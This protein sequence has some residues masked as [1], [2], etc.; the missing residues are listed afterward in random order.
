MYA[1]VMVVVCG[2]MA[3]QRDLV[4]EAKVAAARADGARCIDKC[5]AWW[6]TPPHLRGLLPEYKSG[7]NIGG[8]RK[9]DLRAETRRNLPLFWKRMNLLLRGT[10]V[11]GG[12]EEMTVISIKPSKSDDDL[13]IFADVEAQSTATG[14]IYDEDTDLMEV[15][16]GTYASSLDAMLQREHDLM[17]AAR[18]A[19]EPLQTFVMGLHGR[20]GQDSALRRAFHNDLF[21]TDVMNLTTELA[22]IK[23]TADWRDPE[24]WKDPDPQPEPLRLYYPYPHRARKPQG[25]GKRRSASFSDDRNTAAARKRRADAAMRNN[26]SSTAEEVIDKEEDDEEED[27]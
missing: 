16:R 11:N 12:F 13:V 15:A 27:Q 1:C 21:A 8:V 6:L 3:Q 17:S 5:V 14:R 20:A 4:Y 19:D 25:P 24:E 9:K 10:V 23:P 7:G 2:E 18:E 26:H 22:Q